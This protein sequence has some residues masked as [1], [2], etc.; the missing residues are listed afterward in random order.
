MDGECP[1]GAQVDVQ[2]DAVRTQIEGPGERGERI[3][4]SLAGCP[5]MSDN[6]D[7]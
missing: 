7:G 4:R 1:V 6:F 3:F 5:A 2:L